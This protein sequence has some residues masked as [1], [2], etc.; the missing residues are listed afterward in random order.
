L[1]AVLKRRLMEQQMQ[2][3]AA[4][5]AEEMA[6]RRASLDAETAR[7]NALDAFARTKYNDAITQQ[8]V[9]NTRAD[10]A[11]KLDSAKVDEAQAQHVSDNTPQGSFLPV[12]TVR[13]FQ[14]TNRSHLAPVQDEH[15][16]DVPMPADLPVARFAGI[17]PKASSQS[18]LKLQGKNGEPVY[19]VPTPEELAS[20]VQAYKEPDKAPTPYFTPTVFIGAD[21]K[22]TV[23][24]FNSRTG[25]VTPIETPGGAGPMQPR[26]SATEQTKTNE[27]AGSLN[28]LEGIKKSY[29]S[30][31]VGP[32]AGR[33]YSAGTA[34]PSSMVTLPK[35]FAEFKARV[36][37]NKNALIKAITGA[38]MSEPE[39]KRLMEQIPDVNDRPDIFE[40]KM[41]VQEELTRYVF[42]RWAR[43]E[44]AKSG[45]A[46]SAA[47]PAV[48]PMGLRK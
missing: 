42:D 37:S 31:L 4:Q 38:Q 25:S 35:G 33:A 21:G 8:G 41:A 45:A 17:P 11:A 46:P 27:L 3:Q 30:E 22:P 5:Q 39:A 19:R 47:A 18:P 26:L 23:G 24:G 9:E 40:A 29:R 36:T 12:D 14:R 10:N 28:N 15:V 16:E 44:A 48:D 20:G 1:E 13:L 6:L 43:A 32:L 34:L 7:A 2:Q